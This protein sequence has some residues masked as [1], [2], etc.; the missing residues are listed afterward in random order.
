ML[1]QRDCLRGLGRILVNFF[2]FSRYNLIRVT[3]SWLNQGHTAFEL[4]T[5]CSPKRVQNETIT[6]K[7]DG[8]FAIV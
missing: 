7:G 2:P 4:A 6:C 8:G 1:G 5:V 3:C